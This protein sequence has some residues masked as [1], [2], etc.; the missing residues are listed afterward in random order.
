MW[1]FKRLLDHPCFQVA[2]PAC[3]KLYVKVEIQ[4]DDR[5]GQSPD[6]EFTAVREAMIVMMMIMMMMITR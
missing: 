2:V 6:S 5:P 3:T 1:L 4:E